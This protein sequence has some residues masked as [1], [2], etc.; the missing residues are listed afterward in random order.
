MALSD[1][2]REY[3]HLKNDIV[4]FNVDQGNVTVAD[5]IQQH[6]GAKGK[7]WTWANECVTGNLVK[8]TANWRVVNQVAGDQ[9][10]LGVAIQNAAYEESRNKLNL[11]AGVHSSIYLQIGIEIFG[12]FIRRV[13][14]AN[15]APSLAAGVKP[16]TTGP[17]AHVWEADTGNNTYVLYLDTGDSFVIVLF[18]F[19]GAF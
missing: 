13:T 10:I 1:I 15:T 12:D 8:I 2:E 7:T 9:T 17:T 18:G 3:D 16:N 19:W 5:A 6:S 4:T 14:Y 11:A